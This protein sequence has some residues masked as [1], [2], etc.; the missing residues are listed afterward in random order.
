MNP[1]LLQQSGSNPLSI[2]LLVGMVAVFYFFIMR[3]QQQ[4]QKKQAEFINNL[5]KG[6][7]VVT[8]GGIHG[9]IVKVD[10]KTVSLLVDTKTFLTIEK[11]NISH[12]LTSGEATT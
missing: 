2:A 3:P 10:E 1:I 11:G 5:A 12:E 6:A 7:S 4:R 9:K 8:L